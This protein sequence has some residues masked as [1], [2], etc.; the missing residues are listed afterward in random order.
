[1]RDFHTT[2]DYRQYSAVADLHTFRLIVPHALGFSIF[3]SRILATDL[4]LPP[5][6]LKSHMKSSF[7]HLIPFLALILRLPTQLSSK[8]ISRQTGVLKLDPRLSTRLLCFYYFSYFPSD[9]L[10]SF[11][12]PRHGPHGKHPCIVKEACLLVH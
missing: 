2:R 1:V 7:H 12:S 10:C 4:H 9:L 3:T 8:L 5:R 11:I 6:H